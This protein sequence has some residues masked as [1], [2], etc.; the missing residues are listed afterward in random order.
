[1]YNKNSN[2][3]KKY[4]RNLTQRA[5]VREVNLNHY[6]FTHTHTIF[7]NLHTHNVN[8]FV[9]IVVI[10]NLVIVGEENFGSIS[11]LLYLQLY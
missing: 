5:D 7:I 1:M 9:N 6:L 8:S 10:I 2:H 3:Y 11:K 4:E